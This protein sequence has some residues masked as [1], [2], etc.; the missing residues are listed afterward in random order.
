[1]Q[2]RYGH[3]ARERTVGGE[4]RV[5]GSVENVQQIKQ[6]DLAL[7]PAARRIRVRHAAETAIEAAGEVL[8]KPLDR[9]FLE[10]ILKSAGEERTA[11][12]GQNDRILYKLE[13]QIG[14]VIQPVSLTEQPDFKRSV[15]GGGVA[16][17]V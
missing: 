5:G 9:S 13:I 17:I 12:A 16:D 1:M 11:E 10:G 2:R 15:G 6:N 14:S 8:R 3:R 7:G 4:S